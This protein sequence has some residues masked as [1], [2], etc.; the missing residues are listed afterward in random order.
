MLDWSEGMYLNR[1]F[2]SSRLV[3]LLGDLTCVEVEP[4]RQDF[5][6]RLSLWLSAV[7]AVR[8][9]GAL[10]SIQACAPQK[11]AN[12]QSSRS[13]LVDDEFHRVRTALV[14][15]ITAS[16]SLFQSGAPDETDAEYARYYQRYLDQQR[17]MELKIGPL[18]AHVRQ[19]L[20]TA[21][22][23]LR[24]LAAMDAVLEQ[25]LGGREQKLLSTVPV[26]LERRFEQ[27]RKAKQD[28]WLRV[29]GKE[30]QAVLAAELDVRLQPV[31]GLIEA[32]GNEVRTHQ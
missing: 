19:V 23:P 27:L 2:S 9:G 6:E 31:V 11:S 14:K 22:T 26:V 30:W 5:A 21:S 28:G 10:Q 13:A 1:N 29:F 3:R 17:Q 32:L 7:D 12:A 25:M 8:L 16:T 20:S 15:A 4:S 24:Q 18:R